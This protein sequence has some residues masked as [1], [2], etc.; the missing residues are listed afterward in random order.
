M[1][2]TY[3]TKTINQR[4]GVV[5]QLQSWRSMLRVCAWSPEASYLFLAYIER[6]PQSSSFICLWWGSH[7][8][9]T[10]IHNYTYGRSKFLPKVLLREHA[11]S[12]TT[13][14]WAPVFVSLV[15]L[16]VPLT[17]NYQLCDWKNKWKKKLLHFLKSIGMN[18]ESGKHS[19]LFAFLLLK[20]AKPTPAPCTYIN[21]YSLTVYLFYFKLYT[22]H[23]HV[24][25]FPCPYITLYRV[26][27]RDGEEIRDFC[28]VG[29][30]TGILNTIMWPDS[31]RSTTDS[32]P[33]GGK[34]VIV[35]AMLPF[36]CAL[37]KR[38]PCGRLR[39]R[40]ATGK[41]TVLTTPLQT[42]GDKHEP[43]P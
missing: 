27:L 14:L 4:G 28:F 38:S 41:L 25:F 6:K 13:S 16:C 17:L 2:H 3:E 43:V 20:K 9:H 1:L 40:N 22:A 29:S 18:L 26:S 8:T 21:Q 12:G 34:V 36:C 10:D 30:T 39:H 35:S 31:L 37:P 7:I 5:L 24:F 11:N 33:C 19:E 42:K 23:Y 32:D 15:L